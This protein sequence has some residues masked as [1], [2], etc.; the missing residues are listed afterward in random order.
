VSGS[1][2]LVTEIIHLLT[3]EVTYC[4][5]TEEFR[6]GVTHDYQTKQITADYVLTE[7]AL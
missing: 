6:N 1:V 7:Y 2:R 5:K 4:F 3:G